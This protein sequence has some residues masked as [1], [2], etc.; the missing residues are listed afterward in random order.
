MSDRELPISGSALP[1]GMGGLC[2]RA[3][4]HSGSQLAPE[5]RCD[6]LDDVGRCHPA[7]GRVLLLAARCLVRAARAEVRALG[8][9]WVSVWVSV[10]PRLNHPHCC[11]RLAD[12]HRRDESIPHTPLLGE[13]KIV[14][15]SVRTRPGART[16]S[17]AAVPVGARARLLRVDRAS[18]SLIRPRARWPEPPVPPSANGT[19]GWSAG[20]R[21]APCPGVPPGRGILEG[22]TPA[23]G[24]NGR[25]PRTR[26]SDAARARSWVMTRSG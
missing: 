11:S 24:A 5:S 12:Q 10:H 21:R 13:L 20:A 15:V 16:A 3:Y 6:A 18:A 17:T 4:G 9:A 14:T 26:V 23:G 1:T 2:R 7:G 22:L 8:G 19:P 25:V